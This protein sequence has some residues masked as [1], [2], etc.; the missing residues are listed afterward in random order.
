MNYKR[1]FTVVRYEIIIILLSDKTRPIW[2]AIRRPSVLNN[3]VLAG[4]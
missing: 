3:A 2:I 1:W 4:V